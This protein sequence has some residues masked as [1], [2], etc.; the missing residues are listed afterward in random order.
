MRRPFQRRENTG[1]RLHDALRKAVREYGVRILE[2]KRLLFMLSDFRAFEEYPAAKEV[3]G[4]IVTAVAGKELVR[5]FL[6][7]NSDWC[8]SYAQNLRKSLSGKRHYR[9]DIASYSVDSVLFGLGLVNAVTEPSDHG[10]D[11]V[12]HGRGAGNAGAGAGAPQAGGA[13]APGA[14]GQGT[15]AAP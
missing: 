12:D 7:E 11:P 9:E 13:Q 2:E 6:E 3:L 15:D 1:M 14:A 4:D 5:L 10:V 8:L